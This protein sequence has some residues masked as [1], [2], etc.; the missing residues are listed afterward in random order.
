MAA[1][2]AFTDRSLTF[3][4]AFQYL[5]YLSISSMKA[6]DLCLA[7]RM[8][9]IGGSDL[10]RTGHGDKEGERQGTGE[11]QG[12]FEVEVEVVRGEEAHHG[13]PRREGAHDERVRETGPFLESRREVAQG[14]SRAAG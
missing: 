11:G 14:P 6:K 9:T 3:L 8:I 2:P 5:D 1:Q 4:L 12:G 13:A 10:E 7:T